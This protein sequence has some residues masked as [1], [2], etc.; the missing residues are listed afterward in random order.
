MLHPCERLRWVLVLTHLP[1]TVLDTE[2][3]GELYRVRLAGGAVHQ[4]AEKSVAIGRVARPVRKRA[5]GSVC[6]WQAALHPGIGKN[7]QANALDGPVWTKSGRER[8]G[9]D[10][11]PAQTGNRHG[12]SGAVAMTV[13]ALRTMPE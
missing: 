2:I 1:G 8:G 12:D 7:W 13:T 11:A 6:V 3:L 4:K 5:G 10:M 9:G